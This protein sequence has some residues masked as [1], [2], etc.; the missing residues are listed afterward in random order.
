MIKDSREIMGMPITVEIIDPQATKNDAD[1]IFQYFVAVDK[2]FS[3]YKADSEISKINNHQLN[4][5]EFSSDMQEIIALAD[6]TNRQTSGYFDIRKPDGTLDPSG[7][8]KGWAIHNASLI[9]SGAG[10]K[11]FYI[12]AGGDI[13]AYGRNADNKK[14]SVGIRS[15]FQSA[16]I[17]KVIFLENRGVATSG[18]YERGFHIYD[19]VHKTIAP[20]DIVSLTV[21]AKDV[22]E[23]DR[24]ATAA[25]AMGREG[26]GFIERTADLEGYCI[27]INGL[28]TMTSGFEKYTYA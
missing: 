13:Q 24:F 22:Y 15:P 3:T 17:I 4:P 7:L 9:L 27:D 11:N 5:R 8:V 18:T 16:E 28:A 19:P 25:F 14:W 12:E 23:A 26:I 2:K 1:K 21:I 20:K 6:Q 10:F